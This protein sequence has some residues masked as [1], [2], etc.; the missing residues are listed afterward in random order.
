[1]GSPTTEPQ[2]NPD[3]TLHK[4]LIPA[5]IYMAEFEVTQAQ[6]KRVMG[7]NP[8]WFSKCGPNCPVEKVNW[9]QANEF[10]NRLNQHSKAVFRLP[11][12][13]EWEYACR[14]GTSTPFDTGEN[15]TTEQANYDGHHP[16]NNFSRGKNRAAPTVVGLFPPNAWGLYDM[17]G[18]VWEWTSDNYCPYSAGQTCNSEYKV[19]RGG[20]WYFGADIARCALRYT[21]RPQDSGFSL[22][23]RVVA[24]IRPKE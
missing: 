23:F 10:I 22:G 2:R 18:N 19:I 15:L 8:S 14:A 20:S 11:A 16:Y 5:Q 21:H 6:W 7:R 13:T 4:V 24:E 17:H 12:E 3:E 9:Y 1:M